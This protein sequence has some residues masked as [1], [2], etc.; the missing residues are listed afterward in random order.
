MCHLSLFPS[1]FLLLFL[2]F[3]T[4]PLTGKLAQKQMARVT[5]PFSLDPPK[6]GPRDSVFVLRPVLRLQRASVGGGFLGRT[7]NL[8]LGLQ[9]LKFS[10]PAEIKLQTSPSELEVPGRNYTSTSPHSFIFNFPATIK[11]KTLSSEL[12]FCFLKKLF[13]VEN[14]LE[15]STPRAIVV[16]LKK[17]FHM[18]SDYRPLWRGGRRRASKKKRLLAPFHGC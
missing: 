10:L 13:F 4:P 11:L 14:Q 16:V 7:P 5:H 3:P 8:E 12:K 1:S 18:N 6:C 17:N 9:S 15:T 2:C